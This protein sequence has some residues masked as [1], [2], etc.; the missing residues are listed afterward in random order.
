MPNDWLIEATSPSRVYHT[1]LE[2]ADA[3]DAVIALVRERSERLSRYQLGNLKLM[4]RDLNAR[5]LRWKPGR[6]R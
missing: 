1:T 3:L 6:S 2:P 5:T 4:L